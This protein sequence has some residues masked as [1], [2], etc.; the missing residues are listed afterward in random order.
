MIAQCCSQLPVT[1][2]VI[3]PSLVDHEMLNLN[4]SGLEPSYVTNKS[5]SII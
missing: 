5:A 2:L 4:W 3:V 1:L